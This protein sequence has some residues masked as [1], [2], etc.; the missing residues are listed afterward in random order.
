MKSVKQMQRIKITEQDNTQ[1]RV[2]QER[3]ES[4]KQVIHT[5]YKQRD[6]SRQTRVKTHTNTCTLCPLAR[7][8]I[9]SIMDTADALV[10]TG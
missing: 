2:K 9:H 8:L 5:V 7:P 3:G 10:N 4:V 1:P 6:K